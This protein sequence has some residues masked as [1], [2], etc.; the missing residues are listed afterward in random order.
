MSN[1]SKLSGQ[2]FEGYNLDW[3]TEYFGVKAAR[4]IL[5]SNISEENF[6]EIV[7][8]CKQ[9]D[10]VTILNTGN[11]TK[12]NYWISMMSNAFLTDMNVQ[13]TKKIDEKPD[14]VDDLTKVYK[15]Y[16]RDE[17]VIKIA[18]MAFQ[19]SRF[20]NDPFLKK[21][22]AQNIYCH[23]TECAFNHPDKYFV[24]TKRNNEVAGYILFSL[25]KDGKAST[26]E[27]IAVDEKYRGQKV[28]KSL[29]LGLELFVYNSNISEIK[30][31]TQINNVSAINFYIAN[32]F[33]YTCCNSVYHYWPGK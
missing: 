8:Y 1:I 24:I 25:D 26:I 32:G 15:D 3:D 2:N 5:R 30:V 9:Y 19:Y 20:F 21:E 13:F 22:K 29:I 16:S 6:K 27:L 18:K 14:F 23:W 10:F 7:K 4:V 12:N 17:K 11:L 31:G 28:G 33:K